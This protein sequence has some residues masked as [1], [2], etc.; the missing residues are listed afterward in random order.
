MSIPKLLFLES[1]YSYQTFYLHAQCYT[2]CVNVVQYVY[3]LKII[4]EIQYLACFFFQFCVE[5]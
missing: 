4:L 3:V 5:N 1:L 2:N